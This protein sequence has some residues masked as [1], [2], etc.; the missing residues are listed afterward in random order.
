[1]YYKE[2][3]ECDA[4]DIAV[5]IQYIRWHLLFGRTI[6]LLT[7]VQINDNAINESRC[8]SI[9][10]EFYFLDLNS[11]LAYIRIIGYNYCIR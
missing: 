5:I 2:Q 1:M 10:N 8:F 11:V 4:V 6:C 7:P 3:F 9:N